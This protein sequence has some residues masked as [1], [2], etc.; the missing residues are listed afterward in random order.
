MKKAIVIMF[1]L[2][3]ILLSQIEETNKIVIPQDA[4]RYRIIA[5]SNS[6]EDQ[7]LKEEINKEIEPVISEILT[8]SSSLEVTKLKPIFR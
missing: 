2:V 3:I 7:A 8:S 1:V 6:A 4:I 5:N